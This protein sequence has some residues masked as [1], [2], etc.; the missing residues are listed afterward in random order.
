MTK[1]LT[2]TDWIKGLIQ[3]AFLLV[4]VRIV[5]TAWNYMILKYIKISYSF[6]IVKLNILSNMFMFCSITFMAT[7]G[8]TY[9][10]ISQNVPRINVT[11]LSE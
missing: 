4:T 3:N 6:V 8:S 11:V 1:S 9:T 2:N 7:I 5:K 10:C